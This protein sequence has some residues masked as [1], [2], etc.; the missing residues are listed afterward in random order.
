MKE[1]LPYTPPKL[2]DMG[3]LQ[4]GIK[5]GVSE[6]IAPVVSIAKISMNFVMSELPQKP[7]GCPPGPCPHSLYHY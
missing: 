5:L 1:K 3:D 4:S 2:I 6:W 7:C